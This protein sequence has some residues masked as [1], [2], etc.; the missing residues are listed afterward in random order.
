MTASMN[1]HEGQQ[2]HLPH[3]VADVVEAAVRWVAADYGDV[4]QLRAD[5]ALADAVREYER[6]QALTHSA[7]GPSVVRPNR[8][9]I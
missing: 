7:T 6:V 9:D 2:R 5:A 1:E 8:I 4:D 3:A